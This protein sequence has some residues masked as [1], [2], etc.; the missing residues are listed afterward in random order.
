LLVGLF[1]TAF[2][3]QEAES[4]PSPDTF[5]VFSGTV[6]EVVEVED[7]IVGDIIGTNIQAGD[8]VKV[9]VSYEL[10]AA[11]STPTGS[12]FSSAGTEYPFACY[13]L[14]VAEFAWNRTTGDKVHVINDDVSWDHDNDGGA[15]TAEITVDGYGNFATG[16]P[17][18][19]R[20]DGDAATLP[21]ISDHEMILISSDLTTFSDE[22]NPSSL[23][24]SKFD[25]IWGPFAPLTMTHDSVLFFGDG[26]GDE[27]IVGV[28]ITS[29]S[30]TTLSCPPSPNVTT[31]PSN[32]VAS[33]G[34]NVMFTAVANGSPTPALQ[35]RF[36]DGMGGGFVNLSGENSSPLSLAGITEPDM[37]TYRAFFSNS[38]G[39]DFADATLGVNDP[40]TITLIKAVS[41][42]GGGEA[43]AAS[44]QLTLD[45]NPVNQNEAITVTD[46]VEFTVTEDAVA[47]YPIADAVVTGTGCGTSLPISMTLNFGETATCTITNH[48][49]DPTIT[50]IKS[51]V[52]TTSETPADVNSFGMKVGPNVLLSGVPFEIMAGVQP[53]ISE[54]GLAGYT[55]DKIENTVGTKCP[56]TLPDSI[57][58]ALVL[59]ED[60]TCT[61]TNT[62]DDPTITVNKD[63]TLDNNGNEMVS[64]FTMKVNGDTVADGVPKEV[65]IG[66]SG[67]H[68]VSE[69]AFAGYTTTIGGTDCNAAGSVTTA[70]GL[71]D[72]ADCTVFNDDQP[73]KITLVKVPGNE[74]DGT[75]RDLGVNAFGMTIGATGV[76]SGQQLDV[77]SNTAIAINE[78]VPTGYE[79]VSISGAA[80]PV[81]VVALGDTV[82]LNEGEEITCT[83]TNNDIPLVFTWIGGVDD[84]FGT[85]GN[86]DRGIPP[87][88]FDTLNLV[89][90]D[91]PTTIKLFSDFTLTGSLTIPTGVTFDTQGNEFKIDATGPGAGTVTNNGNFIN[92]ELIDQ[93]L[94]IGT[95]TTFTNNGALNN[96]DVINNNGTL[97]N[98]VT[99]TI[100]SSGTITNGHNTGT[101]IITNIGLITNSGD[102]DNNAGSTITNTGQITNTGDIDNNAGSTLTNTGGTITNDDPSGSFTNNGSI[103]GGDIINE[104]LTTFVNTLTIQN[105]NITNGNVGGTEPGIFNNTS[106]GTI[107]IGAANNVTNNLNSFFN[108]TGTITNNGGLIDNNASFDNDGIITNTG[109]TIDNAGSITSAGT[110]TN[111][112]SIDND[113]SITSAGTITNTGGTITN[114]DP[115][116]SFTNTGSITGGD[117]VNEAA[118]T[119]VNS[120]TGT[121][122]NADITNGDAAGTTPGKL[123]NEENGQIT[124]S[125]S[126]TLLNNPNSVIQ[127]DGNIDSDGTIINK[128][129]IHNTGSS[130]TVA[131][132]STFTNLAQVNNTGA[133]SNAGLFLNGDGVVVAILHNQLGGSLTN[134]NL[135]NNTAASIVIVNSSSSSI[136]NNAGFFNNTV[137]AFINTNRTSTIDNA[138]GATFDNFG[139]INNRGAIT[140]D[141]AGTF[142]NTSPLNN[143]CAGTFDGALTGGSAAIED[144]CI[145]TI[146]V[147]PPAKWDHASDAFGTIEGD[148]QFGDTL[149]LRW[150]DNEG[151][152]T[153]AVIDTEADTFDTTTTPAGTHEYAH[154]N[155]GVK[156]ITTF[157]N[158]TSMVV[159]DSNSP[160][161]EFTVQK[162]NTQLNI[163]LIQDRDLTD[164]YA[165]SVPWDMLS[166][167]TMKLID[168]DDE[169][170]NTGDLSGKMFNYSGSALNATSN[171]IFFTG[172]PGP[173]P[174]MAGNQSELVFAEAFNVSPSGTPDKN[175]FVEFANHDSNKDSEY[176]G[177]T[178]FTDGAT[179]P[180]VNVTAHHTQ[181]IQNTQINQY[182][183]QQIMAAGILIDLNATGSTA[184]VEG[185][186]ITIT[187]TGI[188]EGSV[189]A[190]TQ[191][192]TINYDG[193]PRTVFGQGGG[194]VSPPPEIVSCTLCH[195]TPSNVLHLGI[196]SSLNFISLGETAQF[197]VQDS[198][199][200][201]FQIFFLDDMGNPIDD[202]YFEPIAFTPILLD[203]ID[204]DGS[205]FTPGDTVST[206]TASAIVV[207]DG[208]NGITGTLTISNP[209]AVFLPEQTLTGAISGSAETPDETVGA[210]YRGG[211]TANITFPIGSEIG[212]LMVGNI[213]GSPANPLLGISGGP[214][215]PT[216]TV[217]F[218]F[219]TMTRPNVQPAIVFE[220]DFETR[221]LQDGGEELPVG[222]INN[223]PLTFKHGLYASLATVPDVYPFTGAVT[224]S[225]TQD[226]QFFDSTGITQSYDSKKNQGYA[227]GSQ[228]T[229]AED[230]GTGFVAKNCG[231]NQD[232]DGDSV[233][234]VDDFQHQIQYQAQSTLLQYPIRS[235]GTQ[236]GLQ[237]DPNP[238]S[239]FA[240]GFGN[241]YEKDVFLEIDYMKGHRPD[242]AALND[243][244]KQFE[245]SGVEGG[246]GS[247]NNKGINLHIHVDE[248]L[249]HD[250]DL[251][252][253]RDDITDFDFDNDFG[254]IKK[255][256]FGFPDIRTEITQHTANPGNFGDNGG[257][258]KRLFIKAS[259][260][261][262]PMSTFVRGTASWIA[263]TN[264]VDNG[265]TGTDDCAN[266][267]ELDIFKKSQFGETNSGTSSQTLHMYSSTTRAT[268]HMTEDPAEWIWVV[269]SDINNFVTGNGFQN[270]DMGQVI[271]DYTLR[272]SGGVAITDCRASSVTAVPGGMWTTTNLVQAHAQYFHYAV[273]GHNLAAVDDNFTP[274]KPSDDTITSGCGLPSGIAEGPGNDIVVTLGCNWDANLNLPL[275]DTGIG[276]NTDSVAH[277]LPDVVSVG[278]QLQQAGTLM[279]EFGHNLGLLHNG[280]EVDPIT[281]IPF[282][283]TATNCNPIHRGIMPYS[284]QLDTFLTGSN[285]NLNYSFGAFSHVILNET[286]SGFDMDEGPLTSMSSDPTMLNPL[287]VYGT[288]TGVK[289]ALANGVAIFN[290]DGDG[291]VGEVS[292]AST[293]R[294]VNDFGF[295]GCSATPGQQLVD[296]NEWDNLRYDFRNAAGGAFDNFIPLGELTQNV[297]GAAGAS[298]DWY[299]G[300]IP[301]HTLNGPLH[302]D[303]GDGLR[304]E[305]PVGDALMPFDGNPNDD[306]DCI[307]AFGGH[308]FGTGSPPN[309]CFDINGIIL[310]G[311]T[312]LIDEDLPG[313]NNFVTRPN[314][315]ISFSFQ[316]F[317]CS[318]ENTNPVSPPSGPDV[319]LGNYCYDEFGSV[320]QMGFYDDPLNDIELNPGAHSSCTIETDLV[321]NP[322]SLSFVDVQQDGTG[323][324]MFLQI[325]R[326]NDNRS[327]N[328]STC[329]T[330]LLPIHIHRDGPNGFYHLMVDPLNIPV[331]GTPLG[332]ILGVINNDESTM[333]TVLPGAGD[334]AFDMVLRTPGEGGNP[335]T[336]SIGIDNNLN[337]FYRDSR[338]ASQGLPIWDIPVDNLS[339]Y[340]SESPGK[341]S[342]LVTILEDAI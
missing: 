263:V 125:V 30:T 150:G 337:G 15:V 185:Q 65:D 233:C 214:E 331:A 21:D 105:A 80:C 229:A 202:E 232:A 293:P 7:V 204:G 290:W 33:P 219:L 85:A 238:G 37:G 32:V 322:R 269:E 90:V 338:P 316:F 274:G 287:L 216:E 133:I 160:F 86:W 189:V 313:P 66:P 260:L 11:G 40:P 200:F 10:A 213:T 173:L 162:H 98:S 296:I 304:G 56:A 262:S 310:P 13:S 321:C 240:F 129:I 18:Y 60:I 309:A 206:A 163:V 46:G 315:P 326:L 149:E 141:G 9:H 207:S 182:Q 53:G 146:T 329:V 299:D 205:G 2:P 154:G 117:L 157:L 12:F 336:F 51:V 196:G 88:S 210:F 209:T 170:P 220:T 312:E 237:P 166:N 239:K 249:E 142:S 35:W 24:I 257:S 4:G 311:L 211:A 144:R 153:V 218:T 138:A 264:F 339:G 100:T 191:G 258:N 235:V 324:Q 48:D 179:V 79:F 89:D 298:S 212:G 227:Q 253:W 147:A 1:A 193:T 228:L 247:G 20:V 165:P 119:F 78:A 301:F 201:A 5:L 103:T 128:G 303:D 38:F 92:N 250:N 192:I 183:G 108:N 307:D 123:I 27:A 161:Y 167:V 77:D 67:T 276:T 168:L 284:G 81:T 286:G 36:D 177:C 143:L 215:L 261:T 113:G 252:V 295:P 95:G 285:F 104:A 132:G 127:N 97:V 266:I 110:I 159:L 74:A 55:F 52:M 152:K 281:E 302:D 75:G 330:D 148:A 59:G 47:G 222:V 195:P 61:I 203:Y 114:N 68:S 342:L 49:D 234:N 54:V 318:T 334:Y 186:P 116:G 289:T 341:T 155:T 256:H 63:L 140:N 151:S 283:G 134:T 223:T 243:I 76:N 317:Q 96:P 44:F 184:N 39:D 267:A 176:I 23:D 268:P 187:G 175:I 288:P 230:S 124:L 91:A 208:G 333:C 26:A 251:F 29:I 180:K 62:D 190:N 57:T 158:D 83:I 145:V 111:T 275:G 130:I 118:T 102:I 34:A 328:P 314:D 278:S 109:G 244:V 306:L 82:T 171:K 136:V 300:V 277:S 236:P 199:G 135:F 294:D 280:P 273:F 115:S 14:E 120:G 282:V 50:L 84:D 139:T 254:S 6:T 340:R 335:A 25:L 41:N 271:I 325:A 121:I 71:G 31:P 221:A 198:A 126:E 8:P 265:A 64:S 181:I 112:G 297:L 131:A 101:G 272:D 45:G 19:T 246:I 194:H 87:A 308:F 188:D 164:G 279:H 217:G 242:I 69:V 22:S 58:D 94:N 122:T 17:A 107:T 28:E 305:D 93:T 156:Q 291:T 226:A 241:T 42:T 16:A 172:G 224:A 323:R 73:G 231:T 169:S 248:E 225:S 3:L 270:Q 43:I 174:A 319:Q 70:L 106:T 332:D 320:M 99:G 137:G 327:A 292:A 259:D 178:N 255:R 245:Q 197:T 72:T